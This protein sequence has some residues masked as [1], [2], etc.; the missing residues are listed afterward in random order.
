VSV[1]IDLSIAGTDI[2]PLAPAY[3]FSVAV[4]IMIFMLLLRPQGL[5]GAK[6]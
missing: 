2:L 4:V 3:K 5:F 1:G 6:A